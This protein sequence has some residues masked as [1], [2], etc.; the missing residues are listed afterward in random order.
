[1]LKS[2]DIYQPALSDRGAAAQWLLER[3]T[4]QVHVVELATQVHH[5]FPAMFAS[6]VD[7]LQFVKQLAEHYS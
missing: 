3:M 7:A 5:R 6:D 1:M 4:G 2:S